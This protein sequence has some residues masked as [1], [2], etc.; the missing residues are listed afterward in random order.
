[1]NTNEAPFFESLI[2]DRVMKQRKINE[3]KYVELRK[4]TEK[5]SVLEF[6]TKFLE[7]ES[8]TQKYIKPQS[9]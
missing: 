1:M 5:Q 2:D 4:Q 3:S 6:V 8:V 9:I 7:N